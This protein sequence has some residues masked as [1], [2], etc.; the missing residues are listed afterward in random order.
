MK[1]W[2]RSVR[3]ESG[4]ELI[5]A[6]L[7][8]PI[9][10]L[11][12]AFLFY[13]G[14]YILQSVTISCYA[15]KVAMLAARE[16]SYPGYIN[17]VSDPEAV[18]GDAAIELALNSYESP[19]TADENRVTVN[20][21]S[22]ALI[23]IPTSSSQAEFYAYRF[24]KKNP[25]YKDSLDK[26]VKVMQTLVN[27]NSIANAEDSATVTVSAQNCIVAQYVNVDV[28]Q[29]LV[30]FGLL[31]F[32]G[33]E[34]PTVS[35]SA[36]AAATD[37]DEF[38]RNTDFVVDTIQIVAKKFGI[39]VKSIKSKVQEFRVKFL[40]KDTD[41]DEEAAPVLP[42]QHNV[43]DAPATTTTA[44]DVDYYYDEYDDNDYYDED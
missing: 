10:L 35:A 26:Y 19:V 39:D 27:E 42:Q 8:Y 36:R 44:D 38:V 3:D 13:L 2:I 9:M 24:W 17:M 32:F 14:I 43:G 41:K 4:A 34:N 21:Q 28:S 6:A 15:Q 7:I 20:G 12:I 5:E 40:S 22:R 33:I 31:K 25:I 1:K 23:E 29:N 30:G 11:I 16:V 18:F 37:I